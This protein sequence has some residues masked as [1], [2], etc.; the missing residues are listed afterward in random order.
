MTQHS[1]KVESLKLKDQ[2]QWAG[3]LRAM[4]SS[5]LAQ[6][7][8]IYHGT[9]GSSPPA[10]ICSRLHISSSNLFGVQFFTLSTNQALRFGIRTIGPCRTISCVTDQLPDHSDG[11]SFYTRR[12]PSRCRNMWTTNENSN[13]PDSSQDCYQLRGQPD[14]IGLLQVRPSHGSLHPWGL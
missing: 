2:E 11:S 13:S 8:C 7:S 10:F 5:E 6:K 12:C 4:R 9:W 1:Y 14:L 3:L